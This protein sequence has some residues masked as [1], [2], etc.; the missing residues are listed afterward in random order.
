MRFAELWARKL[1]ASREYSVDNKWVMSSGYG[2]E[3]DERTALITVLTS[4]YSDCGAVA[5]MN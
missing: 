1:G 4:C 2:I 5:S 3:R